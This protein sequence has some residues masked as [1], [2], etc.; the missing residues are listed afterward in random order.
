MRFRWKAVLAVAGLAVV[1]QACAQITF[2]EGPDYRGRAFTASG[3]VWNFERFGFNDR[4]TSVIVERGRW[5]VCE[6]ADFHGRC[7]VLRHG[8]YP[9]LDYLRMNNRISSVRPVQRETAYQEVPPPPPAPVYEYRVRPAE[10]L[11]TV[12]VASVHAMYGPPEQRCWVERQE[13][14]RNDAPNVG[15]AILGG[16]IGGVLGH[17]VGSGTGRDVATAG[18]AVAGAAIGAN[19]GRGQAVYGQNV[20]RCATVPSS[21]QP[22]YWDVVYY[23]QGVEHH[24]QLSAPPGRTITVNERGEPRG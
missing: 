19:A 15:G 3:P 11:Y 20:Q 1:G 2:Y 18:G 7:V 21:G 8:S 23:F 16:I 13:V 17:Q 6:D 24:V 22:A 4:A 10:R 5:E 12:D 9:S 14:V